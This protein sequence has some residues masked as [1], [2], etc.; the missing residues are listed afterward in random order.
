MPPDCADQGGAV[1]PRV[2]QVDTK[3]RRASK[4]WNNGAAVACEVMMMIWALGRVDGKSHFAPITMSASRLK[5]WVGET[6]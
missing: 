4:Q 3:R 2:G 1:S 5:Q 6:I